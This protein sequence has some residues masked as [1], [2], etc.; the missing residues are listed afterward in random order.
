MINTV[1]NKIK[2]LY[3][4][5]FRFDFPK[6]KKIL[7]YDEHN[8]ESLKRAIKMDFD[9]MP[10]R[11]PVI[12]FWIFIKQI[13]FFD[14]SFNTYFKN[15]VKFT[16]AKIII[17]IID[18][19]LNYYTLKKQLPDVNFISIQNGNRD[20]TTWIFKKKKRIKNSSIYKNMKCDHLF[21]FNKY[22]IKQ[23]KNIIKSKFH[24]LGNYQ[25]NSI[26]VNKTK[27]K[28]SFLFISQGMQSWHMRIGISNKLHQFI[29]YYFSNYNR[30]IHILL[31]NKTDLGRTKEIDFYKKFYDSN[32]VFLKSNSVQQSY[33]ILDKYEN[34]IFT[35][36]T[37]GYESIGRKKKIVVFPV[38]K[39]RIDKR[40][41]GWPK[42]YQKQNYNFFSINKLTYI[43]IKRVL[44]NVYNCKQ[45]DWEKKYYKNIS[46][47][48][49]FD[50]NNSR[51]KKT[52][53]NIL[54]NSEVN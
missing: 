44:D 26:K 6:S 5:S 34:I 35:N 17:N 29:S 2:K 42:K 51:L 40:A 10:R 8:S 41:F 32:C 7:Q 31:K 9:V 4:L 23:Y 53:N 39:D 54:K 36:S 11:K 28:N 1:I 47:L 48:M 46:D 52:I 3:D 21:T 38:N 37:L 15:Y 43:E 30:K 13:I 25:S 27:Y 49:Y 16:S 19:S 50:K 24:V 12:Y 33:K 18:N 14:F 45:E 22:Y 20:Y